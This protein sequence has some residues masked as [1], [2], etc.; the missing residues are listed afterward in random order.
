[1]CWQW[2]ATGIRA[3]AAG[4]LGGVYWLNSSGKNSYGISPAIE[5]VD[6]RTE[7][8]QAKKT[9]KKGTQPH[10]SADNW[11]KDLLSMALPTRARPSFPHSQS[12]PSGSLHKIHPHPSEGR[13]KFQELLSLSFQNENPNHRKLKN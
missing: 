9:N 8:P 2:P 7:L 1:M 13:Q 6:Y 12:L 4:V 3:L 5:P 11:I 10:S